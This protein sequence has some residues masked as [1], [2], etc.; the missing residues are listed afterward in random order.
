MSHFERLG[1]HIDSSRVSDRD[2]FGSTSDSRHLW[3][4]GETLPRLFR[5]CLTVTSGCYLCSE[6]AIVSERS[7]L[8]AKPFRMREPWAEENLLY[9]D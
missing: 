6:R 5:G 4:L 1:G 2:R 9:D 3:G 7:G 8:L